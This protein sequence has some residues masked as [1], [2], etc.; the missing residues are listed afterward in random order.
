M[1]PLD[2]FKLLSPDDKQIVNDLIDQ[3]WKAGQS[4]HPPSPCPQ[5]TIQ[6][7]ED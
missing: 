4:A 6:N 3:L 5:E 7:T 2:Q 1:N